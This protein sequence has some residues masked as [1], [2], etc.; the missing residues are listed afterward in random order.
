MKMILSFVLIITGI[1]LV[2][3]SDVVAQE[4]KAKPAVKKAVARVSQRL[5]HKD[6]AVTVIKPALIHKS[7]SLSLAAS[8]NKSKAFNVQGKVPK[9]RPQG[10]GSIKSN[11]PGKLKVMLTAQKPFSKYR[12]NLRYNYPQQVYMNDENNYI[13]FSKGNMPGNLSYSVNLKKG[14][15]YLIEILADQWGTQGGKVRHTIGDEKTVHQFIKF[16]TKINISRVVTTEADGW[17]SGHMSQD[18][19]APGQW[20]IYSV[21]ITEMD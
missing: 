1:L 21:S 10:P 19:P 9:P 4:R 11:P 2:S 20:R 12:A 17:V 16:S 13:V 7:L 6:R 5:R 3:T 14:K 8:P 18:S 15:K